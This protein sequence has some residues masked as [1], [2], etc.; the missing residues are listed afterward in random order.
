[1][2]DFVSDAYA[3]CKFIGYTGDASPLF[4]AA[5][6]GG[7]TDDGCVSLDGHS[8]ADFIS[9]CAEL[10]VLAPAGQHREGS[11][12][13]RH[14]QARADG[15]H[16]GPARAATAMRRPRRAAGDVQDGETI[17]QA[18]GIMASADTARDVGR[19]RGQHA[20]HLPQ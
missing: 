3:H 4:E 9:R 2:R 10:S 19:I 14:P 15:C 17:G 1:M 7:L 6:L 5:G 12:R 20:R 11:A 18:G 13:R 8:A 16:H